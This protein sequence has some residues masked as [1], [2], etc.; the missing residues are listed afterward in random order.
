MKL[1]DLTQ[2]KLDELLG[3]VEALSESTKGLKADLAKAKAKAKG[4]DI[5]PEEY[6]NLQTQ[7]AELSDKL[8]KSEKA[9][10]ADTEKLSKSLT[11]KDGALTKYLLDANLTDN[12]AKARVK[13]ELMDAA[14][15]LLKMQATIKAENGEYSALI[16]DKPIGD[17]VKEWTGSDAGK[18][19]VSADNNSGGGANGGGSN[20]T[21]KT[22]TRASYNALSTSN[23]A[24]AAAF[25][26]DGGQLTD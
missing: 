12:L 10:K 17:F 20:G 16:G 9:Y 19:F 26:K 6:A 1:E 21:T 24:Q 18:H 4:A 2:E 3:S 15:A 5:D 25:F 14:K 13:P 7:V 22:M 8:S 11:E 23:P